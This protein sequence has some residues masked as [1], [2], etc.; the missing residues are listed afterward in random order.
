MALRTP[1]YDWHMAHGARMIEFGGWEMPLQ[2]SGI[3]EEHLAVRGAAGLFDVSHMGKVLVEGPSAHIFL[4]GVSANDIP[5]VVG[6]ARYTHL[7]REDGTIIDD[8][9]V[10][11][12]AEDCFFMVCNAGPRPSVLAWLDAHRPRDVRI[13]D[14]TTTHLCLA[15][16]GPRAPDLL[17]RFTSAPLDA[18]KPF[19]GRGVGFRW[20][21]DAP[22]AEGVP[23]E[24]KG[25]GWPPDDALM[26]AVAGISPTSVSGEAHV[27]LTR[28]GYTGEP[29][30]EL[31]P[32]A[33]A[34]QVVWRALIAAGADAGLR[35]IGLGARDT[36][37][38]EK[39]Y[40][41]SGQ[42]FT[43]RQTPLEVNCAW[44]VKWGRPFVGK[45]ALEAQRDRDA[46]PRLVGIRMADRGIPRHGCAVLAAGVPIG[47]VT[48]GTMS[49]SL[50]VGIALASVDKAHASPGTAL[51]VDIR[52][53]NHP[54]HV[55][56][57][58]FL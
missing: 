42:D 9:I 21:K 29:G 8:V 24:T 48:S 33:G 19:W 28:T 22:P 13:R 50:R 6:R 25:W 37:R 26:V 15:L 27:F 53:T 39:G 55:V 45:A 12:L 47:T 1:L 54:A 34:G 18:I 46:Y 43:G 2:Y 32:P 16:Q 51:D 3:V 38:L 58:P 57:L 17:Q 20:P 23:M 36:L 52:G 35:P 14:I 31:F 4:D 44:V 7:L 40:L 49:P 11:A 5:T 30:F 41:L 10:T 56:R